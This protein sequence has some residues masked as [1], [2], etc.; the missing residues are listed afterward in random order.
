M[1][2]AVAQDGLQRARAVAAAMPEGGLF[3]GT[4]WRIAPR[5]FP[6]PPKLTAELETLGPRL[7]AFYRAC[8]L[9]YRFSV[10]GTLPRWIAGYLDAGKPAS[11]VEASRHNR[12]KASLPRVI[13]PDVLLQDDASDGAPQFTISELDSVPGGIG[14]TAWLN[15]TYS[16][17]GDAVIGGPVGMLDGFRQILST[18]TDAAAPVVR[19]VVSD[20][21]ATYRPEMAWVAQQLAPQLDVRAIKPE[22]I[23]LADGSR[24]DVVYRFFELFDMANV[25]NA[26]ALLE[27]ACAGKMTVTPPFK[28]QLEEKMLFAFFWHGALKNFWRQELGDK[29]FAALQKVI[30]YTWILDS[31]PLPPHAVIPELGIHDWREMAAFSQKQRELVIKISGFDPNAWGA[32]SVTIGHDVSAD[33]W[34][35]ATGRALAGFPTKTCILQR[36]H[37]SRVV[38]TEW[39]DLQQDL[40]QPMRG[41]ARL[42][43]Y[44][45]VDGDHARLGGVLATV[46]PQD[47]KI[48]HGMSDAIMA[49][50]AATTP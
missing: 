1:N 37:R 39:A 3:A 12:F 5:A 18:D 40:L 22:E 36:F 11:L 15:Q 44:Y 43:P 32:R 30:P 28:P 13:R 14:L 9:L 33:E 41:R 26:T 29:V 45:F 16:A 46:C 17:Q 34:S 38:E 2:T 49:P 31:T 42:C 50:C 6:L 25:P 4:A 8:N 7:L 48:L 35:A 24:P 47:K 21:S 20:E 27:V 10:R 23:N 19:I